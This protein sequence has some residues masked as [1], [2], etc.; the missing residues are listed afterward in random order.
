[1]SEIKKY[2]F[3]TNT[4]LRTG[5]A[6][7]HLKNLNHNI[8]HQDPGVEMKTFTRNNVKT[9]TLVSSCDTFKSISPSAV[10]A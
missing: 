10:R 6:D 3:S 4:N 1:M 7:D 8:S 9:Q 5:R 2:Y